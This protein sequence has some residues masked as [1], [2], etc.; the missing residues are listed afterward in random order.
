EIAEILQPEAIGA[1]A[2]GVKEIKNRGPFRAAARADIKA[3]FAPRLGPV[4]VALLIAGIQHLHR[5]RKARAADRAVGDAGRKSHFVKAHDQPFLLS[6]RCAWRSASPWICV[7][8]RR[9]LA[10]SG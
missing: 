10:A 2:A 3:V 6:A 5:C 1:A 7:W 4:D 8:L 9:K